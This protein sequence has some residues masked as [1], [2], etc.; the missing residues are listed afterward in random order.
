MFPTAQAVAANAA[1]LA[2][3]PPP[4]QPASVCLVDTGVDLNAD[5][6]DAVVVRDSLDHGAPDDVD[7]VD[8]T[9]DAYGDGDGRAR[10]RRRDGWCLVWR[11]RIVS[12]PG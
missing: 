6:V 7:I 10:E 2:Y 4:P 11:Y 8:E 9:R 1:W 12:P 3:A 5:T